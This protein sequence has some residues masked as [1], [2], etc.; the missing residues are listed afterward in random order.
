MVFESTDDKGTIERSG[1]LPKVGSCRR[2]VDGVR[3]LCRVR[4]EAYMP[5]ITKNEKGLA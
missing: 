1:F 4:G 3:G 5:R 2:K